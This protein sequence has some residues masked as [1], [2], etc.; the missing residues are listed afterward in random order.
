MKTPAYLSLFAVLSC[1]QVNRTERDAYDARMR[2]G[3]VPI[4]HDVTEKRLA[5]KLDQTMV[6]E[7]KIIYQNDCLRCHGAKGQG[8]GPDA[9]ALKTKPADLQATV[10]E[11]RR[12]R[13][14]MSI[15]RW[16][17]TMPGW[18]T[19]YSESQLEALTAYL[20]TFR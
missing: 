11:V 9:H 12:F 6:D 4:E 20:E 14:Y 19:P 2:H 3:V 16:Q 10:R 8:D 18:K 15:S 1:A 17:G 13:F 7:G 5:A